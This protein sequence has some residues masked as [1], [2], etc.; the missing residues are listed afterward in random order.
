M[1]RGGVPVA[2]VVAN[3]HGEAIE[4]GAVEPRVDGQL[5]KQRGKFLS[6]WRGQSS[7][8]F[9]GPQFQERVSHLRTR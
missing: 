6:C 7:Y 8:L 2:A 3:P 9:G 1:P 5:M 4:P